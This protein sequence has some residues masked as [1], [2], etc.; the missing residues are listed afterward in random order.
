MA[1]RPPR[2]QRQRTGYPR[3]RGVFATNTPAAGSPT[4]SSATRGE[5][6]IRGLNG[7]GMTNLP[8]QAFAK[9][10]IWLELACLAYESLDSTAGLPR[11]ARPNVGTQTH[12]APTADRGWADYHHRPAPDPASV[13]T[14]ALDRP[15]NQRPQPPR[16]TDLT[17]PCQPIDQEPGE[18]A[19]SAPEARHAQCP[20]ALAS[21]RNTTRAHARM[22]QSSASPKTL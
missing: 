19:N 20:T 18:P 3:R 12:A 2:I 14:M 22:I 17:K 6:R 11:P 21:S 4:W 9:N 16:R 7:T 1:A 8:L 13:E 5:D 10:Q 15:Y